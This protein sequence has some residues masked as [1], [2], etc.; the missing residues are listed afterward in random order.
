MKRVN[1][2][3]F[4]II[5]LLI[6]TVIFSVIVL[7]ITTAII[8]FG[9]IY[10]QGVLQSRTQERARAISEEISKNI[11]FSKG[12]VPTVAPT[13]SS[14][15]FCIGGHEYT[16]RE[17]Q[18]VGG[19]AQALQVRDNPAC[20]GASPNPNVELLG[21]SMQLVALEITQSG[22]L[23]TVRVRVAY[24]ANADFESNNPTNSCRPIRL[25]GQYCAVSD[26]TTN[27]VRR[28]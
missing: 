24:G 12:T 23:Y 7:I 3:G 2:K 18:Q 10:Y 17:G 6:A 26:L 13:L 22:E 25:G 28:L 8:Q 15:S 14:G 9:R 5:E 20:P 1:N 11:Q 16:F 4:T 19:G 27:V 21:D